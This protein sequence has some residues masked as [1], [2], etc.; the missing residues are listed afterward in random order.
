MNEMSNE[1]Q[2]ANIDTQTRNARSPYIRPKL[3]QPDLEST[4]ET[5]IEA[6][7]AEPNTRKKGNGLGRNKNARS[8][9]NDEQEEETVTEKEVRSAAPYYRSGGHKRDYET[10]TSKR[11]AEAEADP[12]PFTRN[13][14]SYRTR[15][16]EAESDEEDIEELSTRHIRGK[17]PRSADL[18]PSLDARK[19]RGPRTGST[20]RTAEAQPVNR[21][22]GPSGTG[23]RIGQRA[24]E[25]LPINRIHG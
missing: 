1:A 5:N 24:P 22:H 21:I 3:V 2:F 18:Q 6:R 12:E 15:D 10:S 20:K 23:R 8:L 25:A 9:V 13:H 11:T 17:P 19:V 14:G 16:L 7:F 4:T